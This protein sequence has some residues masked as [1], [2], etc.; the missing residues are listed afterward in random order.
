MQVRYERCAGIDVPKD[1]V[2]V[3]VR[4]PGSGP[5]GPTG[6]VSSLGPDRVMVSLPC[7]VRA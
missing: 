4:V 7:L 3:A 1:Q 5:G 2:T 6:W